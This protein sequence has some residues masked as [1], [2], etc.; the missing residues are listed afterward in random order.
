MEVE[1]ILSTT[2]MIATHWKATL[3]L[4]QADVFVAQRT[5]E[6]PDRN[7]LVSVFLRKLEYYE[8]ILFITTN[9]VQIFDE[10]IASRV[11]IAIRYKPLDKGARKDVWRMFLAKAKTEHGE[12]NCD[13][14]VL[15]H[16]ASKNLNGRE[17][18]ASPHWQ[19]Q[20]D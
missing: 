18:S 5:L 2:F 4:D 14:N 13:S 17:V 1:R 3:L 20:A 11:H 8:G 15:E 9:R 6:N 12:A 19:R 10:A 16:V 7:A